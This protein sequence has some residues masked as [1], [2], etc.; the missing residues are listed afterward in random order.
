MGKRIFICKVF[1]NTFKLTQKIHNFYSDDEWD[2]AR[3]NRV[4]QIHL[5][6]FFN[7]VTWGSKWVLMNW[8]PPPL[9]WWCCTKEIIIETSQNL[10]FMGYRLSYDRHANS[11]NKS[12][13]HKTVGSVIRKCLGLSP[14]IFLSDTQRVK[15]CY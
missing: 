13:S 3:N 15:K 9:R 8:L 6:S 2:I 1:I 12:K 4:T 10:L 11:W 5:E 14:E 7:P